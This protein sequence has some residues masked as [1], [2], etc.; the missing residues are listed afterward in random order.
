MVLTRAESKAALEH[1]LDYVFQLPTNHPLIA[2]L[3]LANI[4]S[5]HDL[6]TMSYD[7]IFDLSYFDDQGNE[8]QIPKGIKNLVRALKVY[9]HH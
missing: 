2:A 4:F 1:V 5:I 9:Y 8:A 6:L 3:D 7:Q